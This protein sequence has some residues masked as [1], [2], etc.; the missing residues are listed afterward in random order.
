MET[1]MITPSRFLRLTAAFA[2]L[3]AFTLYAE[4]Q[5]SAAPAAAEANKTAEAAAEPEKKAGSPEAERMKAEAEILAEKREKSAD[6][7]LKMARNDYTSGSYRTASEHA[8]K[9]IEILRDGKPASE[10]ALQPKEVQDKIAFARKLLAKSYFDLA[11]EM[12]VEAE[13]SMKANMYDEA[14]AKCDEAVAVDPDNEDIKAYSKALKEKFTRLKNFTEYKEETS[15]YSV[16]QQASER[17]LTIE[18]EMRKG[19]QFYKTSQWAKARDH[20][21]AVLVEDPYNEMAIDYLRRC[22]LH[23]IDTGRRRHDVVTLERDAETNWKSVQAIV[24]PANADEIES[25]NQAQTKADDTKNIEG[26]LKNI[27]IPNLDFEDQSL[28]EV[29]DVLRRRSKE[30]DPDKNG[31]NILLFLSNKPRQADGE[32]G[33]AGDSSD[34]SASTSDDD[35]EESSSDKSDNK[36]KEES[37]DSEE[38]SGD[39][40]SDDEKSDDDSSDSNAEKSAAAAGRTKYMIDYL[41]VDNVDLRQAIELVCEAAGVHYRVEP[42]AV[43]I[44]DDGVPLD[45]CELKVF[46]VEK[47]AL[48]FLGAGDEG[49]GSSSSSGSSSSG[50]DKGGSS[51]ANSRAIKKFFEMRGVPFPANAAIKYDDAVSRLIVSNTPEALSMIGDILEQLSNEQTNQVL[52]QVKFVEVQLNDL[53]ELGFEYVI[54][55]PTTGDRN[56]WDSAILLT[57]AVYPD[58]TAAPIP[59][60]YGDGR[61]YTLVYYPPTSGNGTTVLEG[62]TVVDANN[63]Y[64]LDKSVKVPQNAEVT[65]PVNGTDSYYALPLNLT[66]IYGSK[67]TW[68]PNSPLVRN[69]STDTSAFTNTMVVTNDTVMSWAHQDKDSGVNVSAKVHALDLADSTDLL[70]APRVTTLANEDAVIKMVTERY[71]PDEWDEPTLETISR[72]GT[73]EDIPVFQPSIPSFG[74]AVEEGIVLNVRPQVEENF[75]ITLVMT[76]VIQMFVGWTDYSYMM[77]LEANGVTRYYPNTLKKPIIEART[78][79]TTVVSYDGETIVLGGVIKDRIS[80]VDDQYPILGDIPLIGRLFQSKGRGSDKTSLLIFMTSRLIKPDGSPIR[81]NEERGIPA[82]RY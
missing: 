63:S 4:E 79:E 76:P 39:A 40:K 65:L 46:V 2:V 1:A 61:P 66:S 42:N 8:L 60:P 62:V 5:P 16:D 36:E 31:V 38:K 51:D 21:Q 20:F 48:D 19:Q 45:E 55:R 18:R 73:G 52:V 3:S 50:D 24:S 17:Q 47:D 22:F 15:Y 9:A 27:I 13:R 37:S 80:M 29:I 23:L 71:Y 49:E 58:G 74:D 10:D 70:S 53:E 32:E 41:K 12:F 30:L 72:N 35:K 26:K 68:G 57:P 67:V 82:F 56:V 75:T 64:P 14:I 34:S 54:S 59:N 77:P 28:Q 33:G 44:A 25:G 43:L 78:V 6:D 81:E 11:K 69:A 7:Y